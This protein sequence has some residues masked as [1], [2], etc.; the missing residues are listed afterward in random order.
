MFI[1][2]TRVIMLKTQ[3]SVKFCAHDYEHLRNFTSVSCIRQ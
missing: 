2:K 3:D 1:I